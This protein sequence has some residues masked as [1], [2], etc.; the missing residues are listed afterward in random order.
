MVNRSSPP[1]KEPQPAGAAVRFDE[2]CWQPVWAVADKAVLRRAKALAVDGVLD[3]RYEPGMVAARVRGYGPIPEYE[4]RFPLV[5]NWQPHAER[6]ADWFSRH[7]DWLAGL[8]AGNLPFVFLQRLHSAG[9]ALWP[10][11]AYVARFRAGASCTCRGSSSCAHV[12]AAA[13]AWVRELA[14]EPVELLASVGLDVGRTLD[15]VHRLTYERLSGSGAVDAGIQDS[16][17]AVARPW[18]PWP[19]EERVQVS[20][21][22]SGCRRTED[23]VMLSRNLSLYLRTPWGPV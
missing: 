5:D 22:E 2:T 11:D 7:P 14:E 15:E 16:A 4:V 17:Q 10:D 18:Q 1:E 19:E 23:S 6:V 13:L 20:G 12:L 9:M 8:M 21:D 3:W